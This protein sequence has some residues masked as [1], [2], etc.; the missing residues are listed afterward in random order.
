MSIKYIVQSNHHFD[1]YNYVYYKSYKTTGGRPR[2]DHNLFT[3]TSNVKWINEHF[4]FRIVSIPS[5]LMYDFP[6]T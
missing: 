3:Y 5:A 2:P 1:L 6:F 4:Y